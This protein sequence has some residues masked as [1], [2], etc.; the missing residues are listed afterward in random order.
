M[1]YKLYRHVT[2]TNLFDVTTKIKTFRKNDNK[3][4]RGN[5]SNK[6]KKRT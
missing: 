5:V 1:S 4:K 2:S 6:Q 3:N